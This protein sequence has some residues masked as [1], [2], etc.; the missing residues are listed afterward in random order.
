MDLTPSPAHPWLFLDITGFFLCC[1]PYLGSLSG[2]HCFRNVLLLL[3]PQTTNTKF[4]EQRTGDQGQARASRVNSH[5]L[6]NRRSVNPARRPSSES[7][8]AENNTSTATPVHVHLSWARLTDTVTEE[9]CS[10]EGTGRTVLAEDVNMEPV[11]VLVAI[12]TARILRKLLT[13]W[14]V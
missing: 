7:E 6:T 1:E 9:T 11:F 10:M 12:L 13:L 8:E 14:Q 4:V 5:Q 2:I 3:L